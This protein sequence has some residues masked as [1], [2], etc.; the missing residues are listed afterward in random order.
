MLGDQSSESTGEAMSRDK[1]NWYWRVSDSD[2]IDQQAIDQDKEIERL[3]KALKGLL[4]YHEMSEFSRGSLGPI[5][6]RNAYDYYH[7][8]AKRAL[9]N[10]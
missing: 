9:E 5:E 8:M 6:G 4:D 7:G 1:E 10:K 2:P 3:R